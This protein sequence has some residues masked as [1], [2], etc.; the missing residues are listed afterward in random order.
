MN[1]LAVVSL[2]LTVSRRLKLW[3]YGIIHTMLLLLSF[4]ST[5][6]IS[7]F[8]ECLSLLPPSYA[9]SCAQKPLDPQIEVVWSVH[10][11]IT[12]LCKNSYR[13]IKMTHDGSFRGGYIIVQHAP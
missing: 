2:H 10:E 4:Q 7:L 13:S 3:T 6:Q 11:S 1:L 9:L 5:L 8:V 12:I